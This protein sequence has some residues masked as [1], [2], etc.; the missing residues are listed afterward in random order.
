MK[1]NLVIETKQG[2]TKM[3]A[4]AGSKLSDLKELIKN[5][6]GIPVEAQKLLLGFPPKELLGDEKTLDE[7]GVKGSDKIIV[8]EVAQQASPASSGETSSKKQLWV[9]SH[10]N[11]GILV[12]RVVP[13]DNSCLF[14]SIGYNFEGKTKEKSAEIRQLAVN[15]IKGNPELYSEFAFSVALSLFSVHKPP[16]F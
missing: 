7:L 4:A 5:K 10:D 2:R 8:Q 16:F 3:E 12:R 6:I 11:T 1:R 14:N 13:A 15:I 9:P